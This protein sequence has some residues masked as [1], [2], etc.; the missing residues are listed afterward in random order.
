MVIYAIEISNNCYSHDDGKKLYLRIVR[1][2]NDSSSVVISFRGVDSASSSFVNAALIPLLDV[3]NFDEIKKRVF[4][5]ETTPQ[6]NEIIKSRFLFEV[7]Q[8]GK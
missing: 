8:R 1:E 4:F 5:S 2:L 7:S 3:F 6:I